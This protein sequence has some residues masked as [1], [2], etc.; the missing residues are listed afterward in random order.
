MKKFNFRLEKIL[1]YKTQI[2]EQKRLELSSRNEELKNNKQVLIDLISRRES[3]F[4]MYSSYFRGFIEVE[5]L[6]SARRFLD[7]LHTDLVNQAKR[8]IE[9]ER[10]VDIAKSNLIQAIRDRKKYENLKKKKLVKYQKEFDTVQQ[11]DLDEF[12]I[13]SGFRQ[14]LISG[15]FLSEEPGRP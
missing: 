2:E 7:K 12:A 10:R 13:Q 4:D 6:R 8:V 9:S 11:K 15:N 3:Y 14:T 5:R 1:K